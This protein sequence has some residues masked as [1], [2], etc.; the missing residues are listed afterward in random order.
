MPRLDTR[1]SD[2]DEFDGAERFQAFKRARGHGTQQDMSMV[3]EP[4]SI[5]T[6][7]ELITRRGARLELSF[8]RRGMS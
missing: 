4:K 6:S 3:P 5:E 1:V 2:G 7:L 8:K